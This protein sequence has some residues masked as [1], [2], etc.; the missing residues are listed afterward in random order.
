MFLKGT[1]IALI[2]VLV[3]VGSA[4][5]Q[6]SYTNALGIIFQKIQ[7][8]VTFEMGE[9][10]TDPNGVF[11]DSAPVHPVKISQSYWIGTTEVNN[12]QYELFQ[13]A[14]VRGTSAAVSG[15]SQP[16]V[17][18]SWTQA[19]AFLAWLNQNYPPPQSGLSYRLPTE[20]EWEYA[21]DNA[22]AYQINAMESGA[23][24]WTGD[25]YGPFTNTAQ[26]DPVGPLTGIFRVSRGDDYNAGL[27][28]T[29]TPGYM[30]SPVR[31]GSLPQDINPCIGFRI[32]LGPALAPNPPSGAPAGAPPLWASGVSQTPGVFQ[33][34]VP[35]ST[36]YFTIP[37]QYFTLPSPLKG[38]F[39]SHDHEPALT[40]CSNGDLFVAFYSCVTETGREM[41]VLAS[42]LRQGASSWDAP[43]LFYD[44]PSRNDTGVGL[45]NDGGTLYHFQGF[46]AD[47]NYD[48]LANVFQ[49]STNNGVTWSVPQT[50]NSTHG[51]RNQVISGFRMA[52]G[53][54]IVPCDATPNNSG[55]TA[56]HYSDDN[57]VTWIDPGSNQP[58]PNFSQGAMGSWIAGIHAAVT[59][60]NRNGTNIL[61]AYG[62]QDSINGMMPQSVSTNSGV[63]WT[64]SASP[65]PAI[66]DGQ[67]AICKQLGS[68][69]LLLVSFAPSGTVFANTGGQSY[70]GS[71]LFGALSYD[72]G[73][74]W[75]VRKLVTDGVKRTLNGYGNTGIF[76]TGPY[77]AEPAGY[78][79]GVQTPDGII[80][81]VSSGVYYS[82]N[83]AWLET[84][85][86]L[87]SGAKTV[88]VVNGNFASPSVVADTS[89]I[90][91]PTGWAIA[92]TAGVLN[93][94][95][96]S[97]IGASPDPTDPSGQ[98][99]FLST[100]ASGTNVNEISQ[101]LID[102]NSL[103]VYLA[104]GQ[105]YQLQFYVARRNLATTSGEITTGSGAVL[106]YG[107]RDAVTQ[108]IVA[109]GTFDTGAIPKAAWATIDAIL[110][111][112][113]AT[114]QA[115]QAELFFN[116]NIGGQ[117]LIDGVTMA[118]VFMLP[119]PQVAR[120][121][122]PS[123]VQ[124]GLQFQQW[125]P[126]SRL[127]E[128]FGS[129]DL[130]TWTPLNSMEQAPVTLSNGMQEITVAESAPQPHTNWFLSLS[131]QQ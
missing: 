60:A 102:S 100:I 24:E 48:N 118:P 53:R 72:G 109:S 4:T 96:N 11:W 83:Q 88:F 112:G 125:P 67:R 82:F 33:P 86:S 123:F 6:S 76:T 120:I 99:A 9:V 43:S 75:P 116:K 74:T 121:S 1:R 61:I 16:A 107:I 92:N 85:Y 126:I 66:S 27:Y 84:P 38:P 57:G 58:A 124:I 111:T 29:N 18:V 68:G 30:D 50:I 34:P 128:L 20:A 54:L 89:P 114:L 40:Y 2:G 122:N 78:L 13:P 15:N 41:T 119:A 52:S 87:A 94:T 97:S 7:G 25:W 63:T 110:R 62:R 70:S 65:F 113:S 55:G 14:H 28:P 26:T 12:S 47:G 36:P 101:P 44:T 90:G 129:T 51:Y 91:N 71:G 45:Y 64:Y 21:A 95:S 49:T 98:C 79:A 130:V 31:M 56:I 105:T 32:V 10:T 117:I 81:V 39:Y 131:F 73:Q 104:A 127:Y 37:I 23:E 77:T 8:G 106:T 59:E 108:R 22:V 115:N 46:S 17:N 93:T 42:R 35:S 3:A 103:P 19:Q 80:R 5:A 69:A